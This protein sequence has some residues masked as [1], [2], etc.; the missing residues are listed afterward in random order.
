M[1]VHIFEL[2]RIICELLISM[3]KDIILQSLVLVSRIA[4]FKSYS[5]GLLPFLLSLGNLRKPQRQRE[6]WQNERLIAV[7]VRYNLGT[8]LCSPLQQHEMT[9]FWVV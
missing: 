8:F 3:G 6:Q 9:I 2:R 5:A 1:N 4:Q 7:H